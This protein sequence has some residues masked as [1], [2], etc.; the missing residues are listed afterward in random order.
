MNRGNTRSVT[1]ENCDFFAQKLGD[2]LSLVIEHPVWL[3]SSNGPEKAA[4]AQQVIP[5]GLLPGDEETR[6]SQPQL[7]VVEQAAQLYEQYNE[8]LKPIRTRIRSSERGEEVPAIEQLCYE[9]VNGNVS[10][11]LPSP[12][13]SSHDAKRPLTGE[14]P[15]VDKAQYESDR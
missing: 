15:P 10:Y 4:S 14:C 8:Q 6:I 2:E 7:D 11:T 12:L 5:G 13:L 9:I 1:V 3:P